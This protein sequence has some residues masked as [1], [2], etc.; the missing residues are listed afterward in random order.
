MRGVAILLA[1]H[2]MGEA[3]HALGAPLPGNVLGLILFTLC[4]FSGVVRVAW[5]E[6]GAE[7]LLRNML[8]FFAPIVVGAIVFGDRLAA[9]W[10]PISVALVGSLFIGMLVTGWTASLL[11]GKGGEND[12]RRD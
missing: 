5:V 4:L 7:F 9:E 2:L 3:I 1:F 8:L 11:I 12:R 6:E 10:K